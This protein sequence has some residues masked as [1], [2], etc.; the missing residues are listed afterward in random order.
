VLNDPPGGITPEF[1]APL[2]AVD[3]CVVL[4]LFRHVTLPPTGTLMGFG[5]KAV[6]VMKLALTTIAAETFAGG[7][8]EGVGAGVGAGAGGGTGAGVGAGD[9]GVTGAGGN[10]DG[11]GAG[12]GAGAGAGTSTD[13]VV[14]GAS[15]LDDPQAARAAVRSTIAPSRR[16]DMNP[17]LSNETSR[18]V[19]KD[20]AAD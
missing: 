1:H 7:A 2:F 6:D 10:G 12:A 4:S 11:V 3:V 9:G 19:G 14:I 13:G 17:P 5:L 18:A 8:G 20:A 16:I 15:G